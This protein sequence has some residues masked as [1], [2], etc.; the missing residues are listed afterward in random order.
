[1]EFQVNSMSCGH[2]VKAVTQAVQNVD[3]QA[4][5][6]VDLGSHTVRVETAREEKAIVSALTE[7]GYPPSR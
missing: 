1:M 3:P 4:K 5:V 7:A 2:C 6:D